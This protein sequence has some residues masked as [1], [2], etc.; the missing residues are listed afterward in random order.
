M[1]ASG[2]VWGG[3]RTESFDEAVAFFTDVMRLPLD[4]QQSG[5][6]PFKL[7]N[8]DKFEVF[9]P[10]DSDHDYL[11][12]G[13]VIGFGVDD[14]DATRSQLEEAGVEFV[15]PTRAEGDYRWAHFRGPGGMIFE[16]AG[17]NDNPS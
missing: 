5:F 10:E 4:E 12:T 16:I 13:P 15:A 17:R 7:S 1:D 11:T 6:A 3:L 8:G 9:G 2:I 14:V